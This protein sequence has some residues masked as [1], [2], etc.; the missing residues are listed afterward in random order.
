[1]KVYADTSVFGGAFDEEFAE[2]SQRF[3]AELRTGR[4]ELVVSALIEEEI[5]SAPREVQALFD[6][7]SASATIAEISQEVLV[8]RDAYLNAGIV[9]PKSTDDATHVALATVSGC[10][11][12][13]SWNFKHIVYFEK[14]PKYNAVNALHEHRAISIY[15]PSSVISYDEP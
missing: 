12:I 5:K 10:E 7:F 2:D 6:E 9:T 8:L 14:V 4:F 13:V 11:L 15:P 3:F 1:M